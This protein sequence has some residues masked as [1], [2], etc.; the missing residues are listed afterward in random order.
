M[1]VGAVDAVKALDLQCIGLCGVSG[2]GKDTIYE[3]V[4]QKIGFIR[5]GFA[6]PFKIA[7]VATGQATFDEVFYTKP[8]R[9]RTLLQEIGESMRQE[10][11][12]DIWA[13]MFLIW[14]RVINEVMKLNVYKIA[15]I[16]VR[17]PNEI[18]C[19]KAIGGKILHVEPPT[20]SLF[21]DQAQH[22]SETAFPAALPL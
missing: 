12:I 15:V 21:G 20:R 14:L 11:D 6:L 19:L 4:L 7:V 3:Q 22:I 18:A 2:S 1:I 8:P 13:N 5:M 16:D 17:H 9:V 10:V